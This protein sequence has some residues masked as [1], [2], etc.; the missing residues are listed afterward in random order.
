[1]S[2]SV[3]QP[4][5]VQRLNEASADPGGRY[6]LYWM[7]K[8]VRT[9]CNHALEYAVERANDLGR[10]LVVAFGLM[11]DYPE[12]NARHYA[13]LIE[14]LADVAASL[15]ERRVRFVVKHGH[16]ADVAIDLGR[17]AAVIVCDRD[18]LRHSRAWRDRVADEM[19]VEVVQVESELVVP[20][21]AASDKEEYAARTIRP[22]ITRL[23]EHFLVPLGEVELQTSSMKVAI[24]SELRDIDVT[25]PAGA[26]E[27]L[28][29]DRC[30]APVPMF[31]GGQ[32]EGEAIF[33][34]FLDGFLDGYAG[35]RNQ[36]QTEDVSHMSKYLHFGQVSPLWLALA[37]KDSGG[38]GGDTQTYLEELLIRRPLTHNFC[39]HNPHYDQYRGLPEWSRKTLA[40]HADDPR[41]YVYSVDELEA[42]G[43]HDPYWNAAMVEMRETGYMHNYMRMYWGKKILEWSESPEAGFDAALHLNN[44]LFIDGRDAN[45]FANVSWVFGRHDRPWQER[46]IF[47]KVRYMNANGL[48]RK[49]KPEEY[50]RKV[51][52]MVERGETEGPASA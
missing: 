49:A 40:T 33:G 27:R 17:D 15:A 11:D 30:V 4:E 47:G 12:A 2:G 22:K 34:R 13:F 14:G 51:Q 28:Q 18:Y 37:L 31:R 7:Q 48:R 9:R 44:K 45:S 52:R 24:R 26:L 8:S 1:M 23:L 29:L 6:V 25:D 38:P 42:A 19:K 21:E 35:N 36:P 3:I 16:P 5:R 43:T 20:L 41:E 32:R 10:P 39:F 50:V 46:P